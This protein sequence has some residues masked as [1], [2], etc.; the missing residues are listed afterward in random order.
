ML[1]VTV[2]T[3]TRVASIPG[4]ILLHKVSCTNVLESLDIVIYCCVVVNRTG[5]ESLQQLQD[6]PNEGHTSTQSE[7][8]EV[9]E[10]LQGPLPLGNH[11]LY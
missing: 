1:N 3:T 6:V 8:V 4:N 10:P 7:T 11:M 2:S 5:T 9:T